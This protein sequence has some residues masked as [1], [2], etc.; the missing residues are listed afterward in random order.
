M[1]LDNEDA[2]TCQHDISKENHTLFI[3]GEGES[4]EGFCAICGLEVN[5]RKIKELCS[6]H[7]MRN[8]WL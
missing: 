1:T 4:V 2:K 6:D 8:T 7:A 3:L 5:Y